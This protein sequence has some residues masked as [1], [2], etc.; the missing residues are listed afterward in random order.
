MIEKNCENVLA[1]RDY[2][3]KLKGKSGVRPTF[4]MGHRI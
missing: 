4:V 2:I 1:A 3:A